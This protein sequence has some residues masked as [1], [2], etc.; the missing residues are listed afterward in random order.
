M[1]LIQ[2]PDQLRFS[3]MAVLEGAKCIM[4]DSSV[5]VPEGCERRHKDTQSC[6][7]MPA[8]P[9]PWNYRDLLSLLYPQWE[10]FHVKNVFLFPSL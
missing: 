7:R 9:F 8:F 5:Q 1:G 4:G 2:T 3:Y 10:W 6:T